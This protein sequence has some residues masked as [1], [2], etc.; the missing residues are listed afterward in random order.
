VVTLSGESRTLVW[1]GTGRA[2]ATRGC[3][4]A[5]TPVMVK[6]NTFADNVPYHDLRVTKGHAFYLDGVLIPAEFLVNHRS[7]IWDNRT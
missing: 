1:I 4:G 6:K 3:R 7:I 2:L 5:A